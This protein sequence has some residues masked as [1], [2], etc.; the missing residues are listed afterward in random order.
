MNTLLYRVAKGFLGLLQVMP[1]PVVARLG[2]FL[3]A[4]THALDARHR[5]AARENLALAFGEAL[6]PAEVRRLASENFRRIGENFASAVR[7]LAM[8]DDE[9]R[10]VL[11]VAGAEKLAWTNRPNA[12]S[13]VV[14]I[15]HFGNFELYARGNLF[16]PGLQYAT[17]YR[18]L[19]QPALNRLMQ[20]IRARSGCLFFERR[21]DAAALREAMSRQRI[22]IGFLAD[23][24]AGDRG[25]AVPFFGRDCSTTTAPAVFA[26]RYGCPVYT[27][28]CYR[29][30]LGRWRIEIGDEIPTHTAGQPR[31][32][33]AITRDINAAFEVAVRRD[34]ANWFW[35][36]RRWKRPGRPARTTASSPEPATEEF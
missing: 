1:L 14:A 31:P 7:T 9:V 33:E 28:V 5:R 21:S 3:G 8:T 18:A 19:R 23:Q 36:H 17:T 16:V 22:M 26:L 11:T 10:R 25:L 34:P 30:A 12:R 32:V 6:S 24:N 4:L 13:C 2:R 35:V 15:G 20:D 29:V 27:A